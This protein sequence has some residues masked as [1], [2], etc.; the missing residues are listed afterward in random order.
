LL[1]KNAP[2]S[3]ASRNGG[4]SEATGCSSTGVA[5]AGRTVLSLTLLL[6]GLSPA[7]HGII[8]IGTVIGNRTPKTKSPAFSKRDCLQK[9]KCLQQRICGRAAVEPHISPL[10]QELLREE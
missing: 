3:T 1:P 8:R 6:S 7:C 5:A 2:D 4:W 10:R 9:T